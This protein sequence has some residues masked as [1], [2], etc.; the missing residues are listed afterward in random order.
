MPSYF[1]LNSKTV[2][3]LFPWKF[4]VSQKRRTDWWEKYCDIC[5]YCNV[6]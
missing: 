1:A 5:C 6:S 4:L 2:T 3:C